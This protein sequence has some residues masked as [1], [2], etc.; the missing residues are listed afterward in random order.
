[1]KNPFRFGEVVEGEDFCN[2]K[3]E[4]QDIK[5]AINN[6]YSFWLYSPRRYGKT[7]LILK[8]FSEIKNVNTIYFDLYNIQSLDDFAKKYAQI[9][10]KS[11]FNWKDDIR[12]LTKKFG[13]YFKNLLPKASF[14]HFGNPSFSLEI[15]NI[16]EQKDIKTILEIPAQIAKKTNKQ[17][18][19]AF[20]EFQEINRIE[21]FLINWMRSS[22]Q[23]QKKVSYI[24]LGSKQSLME[25]IFASPNSAFY[26]FGFKMPIYPISYEDLARFIKIKFKKTRLSISSANIDTI[27]KKSSLHPH[28][29]QYFSSV[30][31]Q[32]IY[33]GV[34]NENPDFSDLWMNRIIASQS[35]VFQNIYDQLNNNQ[36]N[37]LK[38]IAFLKNGEELFSQKIN[39]KFNLSPSST[40]VTTLKGLIKKGLIQKSEKLYTITNPVF[41][42]W[43]IQIN[44]L[45]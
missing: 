38:A 27:L 3:K 15:Q 37:V 1:M 10:A 45:N 36:R 44:T 11:L 30:V 18:C 34:D 41:K 23:T 43:I 40:L 31:W 12:I 25:S 21:P 5:T 29:T 22:F 33:E 8:S 39:N 16:E 19:I 14:D 2:R 4:I 24:F 13:D 42:E 7:S 26:E 9:L 20:D 28:F 17:I 35:I 6:G 32:L